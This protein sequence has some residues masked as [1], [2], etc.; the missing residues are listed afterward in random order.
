MN[1]QRICLKDG[2][3]LEAWRCSAC[4]I[5]YA[6]TDQGIAD[7]CCVCQR[8]GKLNDPKVEGGCSTLCSPCRTIV[9]SE[10]DAEKLDRASEVPDYDGP[11][12]DGADYHESMEAFI[13]HWECDHDAGDSRPEFVHTCHITPYSL[14]AGDILQNMLENAEVEDADEHLLSGV[15]EFEAAVDAFNKAN[16]KNVYWNCDNKHKVRVPK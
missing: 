8:C 16:E 14:D 11:V 10:N 7:M 15:K 3:E 9:W 2:T 1:A 6:G 5:I 4:G 13:D 12:F